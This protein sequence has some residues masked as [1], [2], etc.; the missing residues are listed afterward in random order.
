MKQVHPSSGRAAVAAPASSTKAARQ[1]PSVIAGRQTQ[2]G[3]ASAAT[4]AKQRITPRAIM[5]NPNPPP[6]PVVVVK[7][8]TKA[9][10]KPAKVAVPEPHY[11]N[12]QTYDSGLHYA[13]EDPVPPTPG[14]AKVKLELGHRTDA[15][16]AAFA[17]AHKVAVD[18]NPNFPT[19]K[20]TPLVF[21]AALLDFENKLVEL[22]NAKLLLKGLTEEKDAL[23]A[24]LQALFQQRALYVEMASDGNADIIFSAGLPVRRTPTKKGELP[25]PAD[26]RVEQGLTP[27]CHVI[28][29][30]AVKGAR[31]YLVECAEVVAG[32]TRN[33]NLVHT[34]GKLTVTVKN[35]EAGKTYEYRLAAVGGSSGQSEWS[36]AVSRMA[37]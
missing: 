31:S 8:R 5:R 16:L 26:L 29:W 4:A 7:A 21:N 37:A 2:P 33:W 24:D 23:R 18:G 13:V 3:S 25:W 19:P 34:G 15:D 17:E 9:R 12:G 27:C 14:N 6:I 28:R 20:P 36:P 32:Q 10:R 1:T 30:K 35:L 22:D 11:D